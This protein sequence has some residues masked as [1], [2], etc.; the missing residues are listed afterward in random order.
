MEALSVISKLPTTKQ[1]INL[2]VEAAV[3][4]MLDGTKNPLQVNV[5]LK[6]LE[7]IIDQIRKNSDVRYAIMEEA[8]KYEKTFEMFGAKITQTS[9][10]T[11]DYSG[12]GDAVYNDL[13]AQKKKLDEVIKAREAMLK[14]GINADTGETFAPPAVKTSEFLTITLK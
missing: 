13:V 3:N 1:D 6:V 8:S 9:K 2:F 4:E 12:C 11:Y 5:Q 14:T 7:D 10:S